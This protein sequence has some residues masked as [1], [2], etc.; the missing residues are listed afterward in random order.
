MIANYSISNFKVFSESNKLK[1]API[2]LIYGPNSSGKS[3]II[4][5]LLVLKNLC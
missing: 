3:S 2:T 5:S 4:Q 1:F